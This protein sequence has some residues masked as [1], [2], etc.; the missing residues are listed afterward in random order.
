MTASRML[1]LVVAAPLLVLTYLL[2]QSTV[3]DAERHER[4]L[5]AFRALLL[6]N[7]ALQRDV[8]RARAGMLRS[9]DPLVRS[10]AELRRLSVDL[11][12]G[13]GAVAQGEGRLGIARR[14]EALATSIADLEAL[15]EQ[16]KSRNALL[17]NSAS[18]FDHQLEEAIAGA[19]PHPS[20]LAA[21]ITAL[22]STMLRFT[23]DPGAD[24]AAEL[25][26]AL[27]ALAH[28]TDPR[29]A[30]EFRGMANSLVL[31][32]RLIA[33]TLP[34]V[35]DLVGRLQAHPTAERVRALQDAY[36]VSYG[37][38]AERAGLFRGLIY[39]A[40]VALAGYVGYLFLRLRA[41]ART[42]AE[43]LTFEK[44]IASVSTRF[45]DLPRERVG[46]GMEEGIA[47][48]AR[49]A[50]ADCAHILVAG[51]N[52]TR[53]E[54][55]FSWSRQD[56]A[57]TV[58]R[59]DELFEAATLCHGEGSAAE[60]VVRD[61]SVASLRLGPK[62]TLLEANGVRSWLSIRMRH[63]GRSVGFFIL[64]TTSAEK[65]WAEDDIALLRTASE[66]FANAIARERS[67]S[68]REELEARLQH[69]QRLEAIGAVAGGIAH[70]FNNILG[71]IRGYGE[72]AATALRRN[73]VAR[74]HVAQI[75]TAGERAQAVVDQVLSFSRRRPRRVRPVLV[76]PVI[77]EAISFVRASFP[78]GL[79]VETE[80]DAGSATMPSDPVELQQVVMNLCSNAAQAMG[81]R[82]S[83]RV[84]L[85]SIDAR[86]P[87]TLSHGQ[88]PA[89]RYLR[90]SVSDTGGGIAPA[91]LGR[92]FEPY[93]TTKPDGEG[94]GLGLA[95]VHGIVAQHGGAMH[96]ESRPGAGS[97]FE[98]YFPQA[99][100]EAIAEPSEV[101]VFGHGETI[102]FLGAEPQ[103]VL[104]GEELLASI[105]YEPVGFDTIAAALAAVRADPDRFDLILADD[106]M[107]G[108]S[109]S[110][111]AAA[112][113]S[114]T[115]DI[116]VLLMSGV[117][118]DKSGR[119][120]GAAGVRA[121]NAKPLHAASLAL[122]LARHLAKSQ[123]AERLAV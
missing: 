49:H 74:Q 114:V 11:A 14:V 117:A 86:A 42:L 50:G 115:P 101:A 63:A 32:G 83:I 84:G 90:L 44:L 3:P 82:G 53:L 95:T 47:R 22:G 69:K 110:E 71:A 119:H 17:Q 24:I 9:Y 97:T 45:I 58:C 57:E 59:L 92:I 7:A 123:I 100:D 76:A 8:L 6:T 122:S 43:R 2:V 12:T 27:D 66:I 105:G 77:R 56:A 104:R 113:H 93:F 85:S 107:P 55:S 28:R 73:A 20:G 116:P 103:L 4:T 40:A 96:V 60:E 94:T 109:G 38:A 120:A 65:D 36:L 23:R 108:M 111:L 112:L 31:H 41:G 64:A 79:S 88:L 30:Q 48:I 33:D 15:A 35:D 62:R 70:E 51:S 37:R 26:A 67:E 29:R 68:E 91:I 34:A 99:D 75:M 10:V 87:L 98:A 54:R 106:T 19:G 18:F 118:N 72:M 39:A 16:F 1:A 89:G 5:D 81:R 21:D 13:E 25:T 46:E 61:R 80:I 52:P 78:A 102:L 121:V